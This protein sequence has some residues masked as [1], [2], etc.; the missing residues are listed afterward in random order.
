[1]HGAIAQPREPADLEAHGLPEAPDL[2]IAALVQ[3]HAKPGVRG[4]ARAR[5]RLDASKRA[6]PSSSMT[7]ARSLASFRRR[8][9]AHAHQVLALDLARGA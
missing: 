3:H 2:A 5:N 8:L 7:P 9:S 1:L 4:A 6:G